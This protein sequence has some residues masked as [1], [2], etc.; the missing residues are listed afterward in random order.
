M[1]VIEK[2]IGKIFAKIIFSILAV[3]FFILAVLPYESV[4]EVFADVIFDS[5]P[6]KF[7]ALFLIFYR[8]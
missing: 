7:F 5:L 4:Q 8:R 6:W 3:Y 1:K 2:S